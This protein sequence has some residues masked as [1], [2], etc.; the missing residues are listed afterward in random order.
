[1]VRVQ[2]NGLATLVDFVLQGVPALFRW[3][4]KKYPKI[5]ECRRCNM[6]FN[7]LS[8]FYKVYPV[9]E[10]EEIE[11]PDENDNKVKVPVNMS[12]ANP[13]GIEFDNLYLDMNGIVSPY[14]CFYVIVLM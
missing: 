7:M 11:V 1:M 14:Y 10:D 5:S 4:S 2:A 12:A 6:F 9:S 13:N 3:L 8:I